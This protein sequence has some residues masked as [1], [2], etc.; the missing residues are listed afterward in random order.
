MRKTAF[1]K[2]TFRE[3]KHT[4]SRFLSIFAI[5][6][7]GVAFFAGISAT[8]PNMLETADTYFTEHQLMDNQVLSTMGLEE[9]DIALLENIPGAS[10]QSHYTQD[11]MLDETGL[12]V[13]LV[14]YGGN[15]SQQINRYEVREGRLPEQPGEI[16][17][18]AVQPLQSQ[19][20]IGDTIALETED[21]SNDPGENLKTEE[22]EVVGF[23]STPLYIQ[24]GTR[25]NTTIGS[26]SLDGF[27]VILEEDFDMEVK[28]EAYIV[29]D[30]AQSKPA[31]TDQYAG[32]IED[33]TE[34]LEEAV[35]HRPEE[36]RE[37]IRAEAQEQIDEGEKELEEARQQLADGEQE[38]QDARQQLDEGWQEYEEGRAEFEEQTQQ[39][40]DEIARGRTQLT[41]AQ[42][43]L[44][45]NRIRLEEGRKEIA[46]QRADLE[47]QKQQLQA[48]EEGIEQLAA[49]QSQLNAAQQEIDQQRA[50][51]EEQRR[52]LLAAQEGLEQ[53]QAAESQLAAAQEG[54]DQGR[55]E[56]EERRS[57]L[58]G[59][60]RE[61]IQSG[62][63]QIEQGLSE[64][65]ERQPQ[66]EQ[67]RT[68]LAE[69][70][71][72]EAQQEL[73][74]IEAALEQ[75]EDNR[76]ELEEAFQQLTAAQD[77]WEVIDIAESEL[78]AAQE[79]LDQQR[80]GLEEQR[81]QLQGVNQEDIQSGL[82]QIEAG[83]AQLEAA[84]EELD[85]QQALL[86]G[87]RE[88][89]G[90]LDEAGLQNAWAQ[91]EAGESQLNSAEEEVV[92]GLQQLDAAQEEIDAGL[93]QLNEA[94][95]RLEEESAA[96][97]EE[98]ASVRAELEQ[99]EADYET[100]L[101]E[102][103]D[104]RAEAEEEIAR[105][106][107]ELND[108]RSA[109][110]D[111]PLPEYF[112]FDRTNNAGYSEYEDN[113]N[114]ISAIARIFPVF[115][116]LLAVLV[117]LTTM[118]RMVDEGR[119]NIGT[120]KALGYT[121]SEIMVK[122]MTYALL[123]SVL[124]SG[125]GL[126]IGY[127]MFPIVIF[128][129][130]GTLYNMPSIEINHYW[131]YT[132]ISLI[133]A[134]LATGGATWWSVRSTLKSNAAA[135][136]RPKAPKKGKR[137]LL[138]RISF[139]WNRFSFNQKVS[140][141]NL[142]RYKGRMLMTVIG[143]AGC[144]AL[145]LTGF[146]LSDSISDV[147]G[148]QF[149]KINQYDAVV[150]LNGDADEEEKEAYGEAIADQAEIEETLLARQESTTGNQNGA[151]TQDVTLFVPEN[152]E[153]LSRFVDLRDFETGEPY[154]LPEQGVLATQKLMELFDLSVGDEVTVKD[155]DNEERTFTVE[156]IVENYLGHTLYMTP[157]VYEQAAGTAPEFNTQLLTFGAESVDED[158]MGN[159][160]TGEPAVSGISFV[161][162]VERGFQDTLESLDVVM[163]VLIVSAAALAF[164]VLY[165]LTNIN[166]SE[167][168][169][170]LS[171][172]KVLGFY[173]KEVTMYIYR[174]NLVLTLMGIGTGL[175]LGLLLHQFVI[176]TAEQDMMMF[177][178]IV[179]PSS[180]LY[181][182]L[183][184]FAFSSIVMIVM[185]FKL[186]KVD[187]VE[188]LKTTD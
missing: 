111:I 32:T 130:F 47:K 33:K 31:Y 48:A 124:G 175:L 125:I 165:N 96:A 169:R 138:E 3:I 150:A 18:D 10:V 1:W 12:V 161:S 131:I 167:R 58:G 133:G 25:G 134:V 108:A 153:Q 76:S 115:F 180:H 176:Q 27:G 5:I 185:H 69:S 56:L 110:D 77:G 19:Y 84:Q 14:S 62:L 24:T 123:A 132:I 164:I 4:K 46:D 54:L 6:L 116:L 72:E 97:E 28:T 86:D 140:A 63:A 113:A 52:Q 20:K 66:L 89:L 151:N 171:T 160:L 177:S 34:K 9:E 36:R 112:V 61:D 141:R 81:R 143:V 186:K 117:S 42:E 73:A 53:I 91:I 121:S 163:I 146:G 152:P 119:T 95:Q 126:L 57:Q 74:Q 39:A 35:A 83:T 29:Y 144:T 179:N 178:R 122:Y 100:G 82:A 40:R 94:E 127:Y 129:A 154:E 78:A 166:V 11:V 107:E 109:L 51:L 43:E 155:A 183:L 67:R 188:A 21:V 136:L 170:E 59:M 187:M 184:T 157:D 156:G 15:E 80:A 44:D 162:N 13:K 55:T 158:E 64:L 8:G 142:F 118:T 50:G 120:M 105:A 104:Q 17:L 85:Q 135:L 159:K 182:G 75:L 38:L 106:E 181:S 90:G 147:A 137:I 174:E 145:I 60:T 87:Q 173:D 168:I 103:E 30:E 148:L 37:A 7:M 68:E 98:L 93:Q 49:A 16:A 102:F 23:V 79:E 65:E 114:R 99:G 149:G 22:F 101:A 45:H 139:I 41:E 2:D 172:I 88:Q 70:T 128:N 92:I 26:G 71:D